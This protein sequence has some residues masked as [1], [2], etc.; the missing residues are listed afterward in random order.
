M[1][2]K[3]LFTKKLFKSSNLLVFSRFSFSRVSHLGQI[4]QQNKHFLGLLNESNKSTF[5][6]FNSFLGA[7]NNSSAQGSDSRK[8]H[9]ALFYKHL[10]LHINK[11]DE[12]GIRRAMSVVLRS[13]EE[14]SETISLISKRYSEIKKEKG[15]ETD[16]FAFRRF[17]RSLPFAYRMYIPMAAFRER[18]RQYIAQT[19]G[20]VLK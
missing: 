5:E 17:E 2:N 15:I 13:G 3:H 12:H 7:L 1:R 4:Q 14:N 6:D 8:T 11:L 10:P 18:V 19:T 9:E 16:D 20:I